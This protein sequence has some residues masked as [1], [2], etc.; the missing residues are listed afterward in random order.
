MT[1]HVRYASRLDLLAEELADRL[2]D[3]PDDP[4]EPI[5]VAVPTAGVR[6]WLTRRLAER[7]GVVANVQMPFTGRFL[8]A[9]LG[10]PLDTDDPW[11][12]E[13]LTWAVLD[14]LESGVVDVP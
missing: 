1:L 14:V 2:A 12:V 7:L 9:A 6:D 11:E 4:F 5:V 13:R 8:A 10:T 3:P